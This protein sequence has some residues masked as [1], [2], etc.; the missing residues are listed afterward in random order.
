[1]MLKSLQVLLSFS[2]NRWWRRL[3]HRNRARWLLGQLWDCSDILPSISHNE[4]LE[5]TL[6]KIQN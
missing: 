1:M 6:V 5:G 2:S 3:S 4:L